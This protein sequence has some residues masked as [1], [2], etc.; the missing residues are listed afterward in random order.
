MIGAAAP[1]TPWLIAKE[2]TEI[3]MVPKYSPM[4]R[5]SRARR[6]KAGCSRVRPARARPACPRAGGGA[7]RP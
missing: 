1:G 2:L 5:L 4:A 7:V 3:P 6:R